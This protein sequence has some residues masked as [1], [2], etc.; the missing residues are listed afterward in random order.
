M[1]CRDE[2]N[3]FCTEW[4][5]SLYNAADRPLDKR[6]GEFGMVFDTVKN[7]RLFP[8]CAK[9]RIT[10][11]E[12]NHRVGENACKHVDEKFCKQDKII[13]RWR[14]WRVCQNERSCAPARKIGHG[15]IK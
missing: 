15:T 8:L 12:D 9:D 11:P 6:I 14:K 1:N 13:T 3:V 10:Q 7:G 2:F 5:T 4:P